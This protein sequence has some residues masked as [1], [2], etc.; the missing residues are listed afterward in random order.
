MVK[1]NIQILAT[2]PQFR[3]LRELVGKIASDSFDD[4]IAKLSEKKA[5]QIKVEIHL[6]IEEVRQILQANDIEEPQTDA[7]LY[8]K[9]IQPLTLFQIER[10]L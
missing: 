2:A 4:F 8:S 7:E 5:P 10:S 1:I 9:L 6:L 3:R